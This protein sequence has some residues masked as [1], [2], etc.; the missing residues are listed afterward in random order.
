M[1][2]TL[3][4]NRYLLAEALGVGGM[5]TV[6]RAT[7]LRTGG[8]V[9]VKLLHPFLTQN[10]EYVARLRREAQVAAALTSPRVVRVIDL[11]DHEGAPFIVM[12]YVA[13]ETLAR[14]LEQRGPLP[15]AE[16]LRVCQE[17]ARA[18]EA[19]HAV[20]IVHRDLK[21]D[22]IKLVDGQVKV[23]DFGLAREAAGVSV[24]ATGSYVGTPEYS[25]PERMTSAG[26]IRAD[27]YAVGAMLFELL[28]GRPP[29]AGP[30]PLAVLYQQQHAAVPPLSPGLPLVL[31]EIVLRCLA[32]R[33]ED[34]YQSPR[35]L[36]VAL[37]GAIRALGH[38][39][40]ALAPIG[41]ETRDTDARV[42]APWD[43]GNTPD[44]DA[45]TR[46]RSGTATGTSQRP[47]TPPP[48]R[49]RPRLLVLGGAL[50]VAAVAALVLFAVLGRDGS[51]TDGDQT[52]NI[53][54]RPAPAPAAQ[55]IVTTFAG[56]GSRGSADGPADSARFG[57]PDGVA[58][59]TAGNV[60]VG[61]RDNHRIR[62]ITP[63]GVVTTLAGAG[64][65]GYADGPGGAAQFKGPLGVAVDAAGN[66][67]VADFENHRIRKVTPQGLVTTL[68]GS[69]EAGF[70]D[71]PAA[72]AR[73][74]RPKGVAVDAAGNVYVADFE[75]HRIRKITPVGAVTTLAGSGEAGF[76][77]GPAASARL[78]HPNGIAVDAAGNI[79]VA[80][81]SNHRIRKITPQ[82]L[83]MT[84]AG[85]GEPSFA[86][87][88]VGAARFN[89]PTGIAVDA[90]GN[91][92]VAEFEN[93]RIREITPAGAVTTLAGTGEPGF[94]DGPGDTAQF[95]RPI[96]V[97]V[98]VVGTLYVA[99]AANNRIRK[100]VLD[101]G[102]R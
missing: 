18:L 95:R 99:D 52:G 79:Y 28:A 87:G 3:L 53:P 102:T 67:Y 30:T 96:G 10:P 84:L 73:F 15:P 1:R 80:V 78:L 76:I 54:T 55:A 48:A 66:V 16:A 31:R 21:P 63:Q 43:A 82:G 97:A 101:Q 14:L 56:S 9:A 45:A 4:A 92:Y 71:G 6:Y 86:D 19:A 36:I 20:G 51:G 12:E 91:V 17:I 77:D 72:S 27:I 59:D 50:A 64:T 47:P 25:A 68:A 83:V 69:G 94:A 62:K 24:T 26:D 81:E 40:D 22:N 39:P 32:K 75:N 93:H 23:L 100:I 90:A 35:E 5:G 34:R 49:R 70:A 88:P 42:A 89:R 58:V 65:P 46:A 29:F 41:P 37:Q 98:D 85:T 57:W 7:D 11:G 60:Y 33:P 13:G 44:T 8:A 61:D 2:G 38:D 74:N